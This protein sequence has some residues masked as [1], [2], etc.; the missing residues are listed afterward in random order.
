V[1][2]RFQNLPFKRNPQRY[3]TA[4]QAAFAPNAWAWALGK[5]WRG[6][7]IVFTFFFHLANK[8]TVKKD[9]ADS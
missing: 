2:N 8:L 6:G 4:F 7:L 9:I 3:T 5:E 1:K